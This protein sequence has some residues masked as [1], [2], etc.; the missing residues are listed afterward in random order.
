[1]AAVARDNIWGVQFH[2]EKSQNNGRRLLRSFLN[3]AVADEG[4]AAC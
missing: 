3:F 1:V 2:P 4:R